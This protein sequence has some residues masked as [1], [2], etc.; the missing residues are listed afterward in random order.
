SVSPR[1]RPSKRSRRRWPRARA[2]G[3]SRKAKPPRRWSRTKPPDQAES[4]NRKG[5]A[6]SPGLLLFRRGLFHHE[7]DL[8]AGLERLPGLQSVEH[9]E[10]LERPVGRRHAGGEVLG[11]VA[12]LHGD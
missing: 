12:G 8:L 10:A 7:L 3:R 9:Q 11:R 4:F 1:P 2:G 6:L 5:P